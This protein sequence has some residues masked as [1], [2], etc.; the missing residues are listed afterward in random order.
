MDDDLFDAARTIRPYLAELVG[1]E[2]ASYDEQIARLLAAAQAGADVD[3]ELSAVL[4]RSAAIHAWIAKTLEDEL[5]R[6]PDLQPTRELGD[7]GLFGYQGLSGT[8]SP[9]AADKYCC[10]KHDFAWWRRSVAQTPPPCTTHGI[11]LVACP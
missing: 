7:E 1:A 5:H 3:E 2:A 11:P 10:P 8:A 6:P 9:T 4:Q